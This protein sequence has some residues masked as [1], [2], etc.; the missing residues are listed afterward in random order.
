M[1]RVQKMDYQAILEE[2]HREIQPMIGQGRIPDYIAPLAVVPIET[3]G[4]ALQT[5][6][7]KAYAVGAA[8][9]RFSIQSISKLFSLT[10]AFRLAGA[11]LWERVGREPSGSPF[12]SLVQ[13]EYEKGIPRNPFINAGALVIADII[14]SYTDKPNEAY[15]TFLRQLAGVKSVTY[16]KAIY[17]AE[18]DSGHRNRALANLLKDFGNL[19][20]SV[21]EVLEFYFFQCAVMMSCLELAQATLY[22]A[23]Q[24]VSPL[25]G[26]VVNLRQTKRINAVMLTCGTYDAAGDFAYRVGLPGKSGVGGGIVAV[27][28]DQMSLSVWS[29]ALNSA[30]NSYVG[31]KALELFTTKTRLSVF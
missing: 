7:G 11:S 21:N 3:F 29:P 17:E 30:G 22:L 20:H 8:D 12:N 2:I 26:K 5:T 23:D 13:L 28:P 9:E 25:A 4:M 1:D 19:H 15:L 31:T 14:L 16:S 18:T 24:G 6:N 10:L 27:V